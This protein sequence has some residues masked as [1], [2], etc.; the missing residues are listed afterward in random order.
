M[1]EE[2]RKRKKYDD[3][4]SDETITDD[5]IDE[6]KN[7]LE[8][9]TPDNVSIAEE[10]FLL[11]SKYADLSDMHYRIALKNYFDN[12][13]NTNKPTLPCTQCAM[14]KVKWAH[15]S[16]MNTKIRYCGYCARKV[17]ISGG[18]ENPVTIVRG[19]VQK[20]N[21]SA[22][23]SKIGIYAEKYC[24]S[25]KRCEDHKSI[26]INCDIRMKSCPECFRK[27]NIAS[28]LCTKC[29]NK[30]QPKTIASTFVKPVQS[31]SSSSSSSSSSSVIQPVT[32]Y[33]PH[34]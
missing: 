7:A 3:Y 1:S 22:L 27:V 15:Y 4:D 31:N 23:C 6:I 26:N 34:L 24:I 25:G 12:S 32:I 9:E 11:A 30:K 16:D 21:F 17:I 18:K 33:I 14:C 8:I 20:C 29:I 2:N 13:K 28:R 19:Y 10:H 5:E